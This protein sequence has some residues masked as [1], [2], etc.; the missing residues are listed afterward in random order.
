MRQYNNNENKYKI[1]NYT[2]NYF[3][4][5]MLSTHLIYIKKHHNI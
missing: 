4:I 1:G 3:H 5:L 2:T